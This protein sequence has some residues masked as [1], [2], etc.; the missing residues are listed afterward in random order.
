M[1]RPTTASWF[2]SVT[3]VSLLTLAVSN[4]KNGITV[5]IIAVV[6]L[7]FYDQYTR[8][9]PTRL[10]EDQKPRSA[11]G[12]IPVHGFGRQVSRIGIELVRLAA[13]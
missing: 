7:L 12:L 9:I 1:I 3:V 2:L 11:Y 4:E 13:I 8:K 10:R 5:A 6:L